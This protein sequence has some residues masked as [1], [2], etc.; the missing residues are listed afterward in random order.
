MKTGMEKKRL[1]P[2]RRFLISPAPSCGLEERSLC[3]FQAMA[4]LRYPRQCR[5]SGVK[6]C[7][8]D[9]SPIEFGSSIVQQPVAQ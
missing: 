3:S 9:C 8:A 4:A 6:P 2:H 1:S 7:Y 5:L